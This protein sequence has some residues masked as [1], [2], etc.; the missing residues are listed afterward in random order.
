MATK[1]RDFKNNKLGLMNYLL[2]KVVD[3]MDEN[4]IPYYLDCV[5]LLGCIRENG[6]MEKDTDIDISIHLS[7][8]DKLNSI[9]F[10]KYGL[11]RTRTKSSKNQGYI[12]S[13]KIKNTN[14]Y[15][16]ICIVIYILIQHFHS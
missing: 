9:D 14:M 7:Y 16:D 2:H 6:L 8:W 4:N 10:K 11:D 15:C 5:T 1:L 13:V 12:I 3:I